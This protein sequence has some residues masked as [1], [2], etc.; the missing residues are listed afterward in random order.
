M[1]YLPIKEIPEGILLARDLFGN[2]G[3]ILLAKGVRL[4]GTYLQRLQEMKFS[5]LYVAK[6][7]EDVEFSCPVSD[8]TYAE[9]I[10]VV[11]EVFF[12]V[13][14]HYYLCFALVLEIAEIIVD[15]IIG[16]NIPFNIID[17][18][19]DDNYIYLHSVNV[20]IISTII[21]KVLGLDRSKLKDLAVGALLHD[22]GKVFIAPIMGKS[23]EFSDQFTQQMINHPQYGFNLLRAIPEINL[24]S[25]HIA[26]QHHEREDGSGYPRALEGDE[27]HLFAKITA[28][29]DTYDAMISGKGYRKNLWSH[30]VIKELVNNPTHYDH[31]VLSALPISVALYPI[32]SMVLLTNQQKAVVVNVTAKETTI[33]LVSGN[34][35]GEKINL[36]PNFLI[37]IER[38]LS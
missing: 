14:K 7:V 8:L 29:A 25:A 19:N 3:R 26:Y 16:N 11:R 34:K 33:E 31:M 5:H 24:L 32:G 35:K 38:R 18:K 6:T 21:G 12:N 4:T 13:A 20:C 36:L 2:D 30:E 10:Q 1:R 15:E 17:Q 28:I 23:K 22:I 9:T 37:K 27:I